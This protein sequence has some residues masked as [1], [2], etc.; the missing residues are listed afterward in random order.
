MRIWSSGELI[1]PETGGENSISFVVVVVVVIKDGRDHNSNSF[2]V[3]VVVLVVVLVKFVPGPP[4][5]RRNFL[6]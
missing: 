1:S 4:M 5:S 3:V 6:G 2:D